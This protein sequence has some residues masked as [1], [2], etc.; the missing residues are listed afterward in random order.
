MSRWD[1][2]IVGGGMAGLTAGV[3]SARRGARVLVLEKGLAV[4]GSAALSGGLVWTAPSHEVMERENPSGDPPWRILLVDRF[5][6]ALELLASCGIT[7]GEEQTIYGFGRGY[8]IDVPAYLDRCVRDIERA[9]GDVRTQSPVSGLEHWDGAVVGVRVRSSAQPLEAP[10]VLLA[11]GGFQANP[12]LRRQYLWPDADRMLLRASRLS[13][14]DGLEFALGVGARP[15]ANLD[16]FYGHLVPHPLPN[17]AF[18]A[19]AYRSLSQYYSDHGVLVNVDGVRFTDESRGDHFNVQAVARQ[20]DMRAALVVNQALKDSHVT[21][22]R[23][24]IGPSYDPVE[25]GR[26]VGANVA[27]AETLAA[28]C[29]QLAEWGYHAQRAH[30]TLVEYVGAVAAGG[31]VTPARSR[32]RH[33]LSKPP[34][35]AIEVQPAITF[36]L[37]G[38]VVDAQARVLSESGAPIPGL[39]AAGHDLGGVYHDGY[40]GGLALALVSGIVAAEQVSPAGCDA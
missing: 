40:A 8:E 22:P 38:L 16:E 5:P 9:G 13:T 35:W 6:D 27:R 15:S 1:V 20:K 10:W 4:G 26:Q 37:G 12:A 3:V 30:A 34:Y 25:A 28:L 29:E 19:G 18:S 32:Y 24:G 36:T 33:E 2:V 7:L 14:G 17:S 31:S 23:H 11:T 21:S 39:L